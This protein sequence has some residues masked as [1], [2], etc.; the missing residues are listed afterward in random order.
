MGMTFA[1]GQ[2][3]LRIL[4]IKN[5]ELKSNPY[6]NSSMVIK[7]WDPLKSVLFLGDLGK[8]RATSCSM[9][10][11]AI[12]WT[13]IIFRCRTTDRVAYRWISTVR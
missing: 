2:T 4:G 10:L 7:V 11:I 12:N 6:N 3:T 8:S 1:F 9:D 5:E 13:A